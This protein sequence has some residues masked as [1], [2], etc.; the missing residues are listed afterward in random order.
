MNNSIQCS[1]ESSTTK[2]D[3]NS[4]SDGIYLIPDLEGLA[5]LPDIRT[6]SGVNAGYDG[7][8]T[9]A[10]NYDARLISIRGVIANPDVAQVEALRRKLASLVGQGHK[11]QLTLRIVTEAGNAYAI[12]VRTISCEMALQR[13]L[14]KQEFLIQLRADDPLIYDDGASGGTEAILHVQQALGGF[15]INFELPLA[16]GGGDENVTIENGAEMTYPLITLTGPLHSPTV[17]NITTNQQMQ[18]LA[19]LIGD[20]QEWANPIE[21]TGATITISDAIEDAPMTIKKIEGNATQANY[22]SPNIF[23]RATATEDVGLIW[24]NGN[25][26]STTNA[27]SSDYIAVSANEKI[28]MNYNAMIMFYNSSKTYLGALQS[29]GT[30]AKQQGVIKSNFTVTNNSSVAYMRLGFRPVNNNSENMKAKTDIMVNKGDSLLPYEAY[31]QAPNPLNPQIIQMVTGKQTVSI[32]DGNSTQTF[33]IDLNGSNI[34][35][36]NIAQFDDTGG[37][38]TTYTYFKLPDQK[39]Y[40]LKLTAK[41]NISAQN[42]AKYLGFTANG[43]NAS[44]GYEWAW[45]GTT[46]T[47]Q[48]GD[49]FLVQN[50][51]YDCVSLYPKNDET[52]QWFNTNFD[53]ELYPTI[54]LLKTGTYADYIWNDNGTWKIHHAIKKAVATVSWSNRA[55]NFDS[56]NTARYQF[57]NFM[58][59][60]PPAVTTEGL[61][62]YFV[63]NPSNYSTDVEGFGF[64]ASHL[65]FRGNKSTIGSD[66]SAVYS[67]FSAHPQTIYYPL[68]TP[69]EETI[70]DATLISQLETISQLYEGDNTITITPASGATGTLTIEY[71]SELIGN[72]A[73]KVVIDSQART[74]T[75]NGQDA[76]HLKADG[77]EFITLAPGDNTMYLTSAQTSD[78]GYAEVKFKQGHLTI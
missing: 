34:F 42:P 4:A 69:T 75:L 11:E 77:S 74:I 35:T 5:G 70:T 38:G 71:M 8:W 27:V 36:G 33:D 3:L 63:L 28:W 52:L 65:W 20:G 16:I 57:T 15:E 18:I 62:E 39:N 7:G 76:Y 64:S 54:E 29:D 53:V 50:G 61:C 6:T 60:D 68:E 66:S 22:M 47:A 23:N 41:N 56:T 72:V 46:L 78:T 44:G 67:W 30:Y 12:S 58:T 49:V 26:T 73:D 1:L 31:G 51:T 17:V 59:S 40:I 55:S 21:L 24:A 37:T 25:T 32:T 9:S 45:Y 48:A 19:D 10:Q 43:G 14:T 2:M 13:V